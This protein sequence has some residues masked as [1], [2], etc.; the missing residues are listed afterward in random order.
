MRQP[1]LDLAFAGLGADG[2]HGGAVVG[3]P[4]SLAVFR[5]LGYEEEGRR[6]VVRRKQPVW[7][8]GFRLSRDEWGRHR[9]DD[10]FVEALEPTLDTF[11]AR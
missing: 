11:G 10:I 8:V 7:L 9:R 4:A 6:G 2:A 5:T 1:I 3:N